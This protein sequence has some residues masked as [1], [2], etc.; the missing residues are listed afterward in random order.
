MANAT[1]ITKSIMRQKSRRKQE[2]VFLGIAAI[3]IIACVVAWL[4]LEGVATTGEAMCGYEEHTHS[5]GCYELV[6]ICGYEEGEALSAAPDYAAIEADIRAE[7][8]AEAEVLAEEQALAQQEAE[9]AAAAEAEAAGEDPEAARAAVAAAAEPLPT[10]DEVALREAV[11]AAYAAAEASVETHVH[12]ESCT[13]ERLVCD[14]EEHTHVPSCYSN[15]DIDEEAPE[16]WE[17]TFAHV[18]LT[19]EWPEDLLAI[20]ETQIGYCESEQN[21]QLGDDGER[22]G[23]TR[24]G[25]WYEN[26]Y[27]VWDG[28]FVLFCMEYAGI[29]TDYLPCE[30]GAYAWTAALQRASAYEPAHAYLPKPGDIV[31]FNDDY[32]ENDKADR[33]GIVAS[34]NDD[35][36]E[37]VVI[38]GDV[39][40][41]VAKTPY[42]LSS[43][44]IQGYCNVADRQALAEDPSNGVI[45]IDEYDADKNTPNDGDSAGEKD[46]KPDASDEDGNENGDKDANN[47]SNSE[48]DSL[49]QDKEPSTPS[50]DNKTEDEKRVPSEG[51]GD[52][53]VPTPS[54]ESDAV[55]ADPIYATFINEDGEMILFAEV[56]AQA[57]AE[58]E[59]ED[60]AAGDD[61]E[62]SQQGDGEQKGDKP[63]EDSDLRGIDDVNKNTEVE[64]IDFAENI[65]SS[66]VEYQL[67]G[68]EGWSVLPDDAVINGEDKVKFT[69]AYRLDANTLSERAN[70]IAFSATGVEELEAQ[71]G[72]VLDEIS[73]EE[74]GTYKIS[75]DG[76]ITI[77]FNKAAVEQNQEHAIDGSV[78]F[79]CRATSIAVDEENQATLQF[80]SS[81]PLMLTVVKNES[82]NDSEKPDNESKNEL[83]AAGTN[84]DKA[85]SDSNDAGD[86]ATFAFTKIDAETKEP[87]DGAEFELYEYLG[88]E[89]VDAGT[90]I[91]GKTDTPGLVEILV[92]FDTA[93]RLKETKAP[94]GYQLMDEV[95]FDV[96]SANKPDEF[97]EEDENNSSD[98]SDEQLSV[99]SVEGNYPDDYEFSSKFER[100]EDGTY[101]LANDPE[102]TSITVKKEW[103]DSD[104]HTDSIHVQLWRKVIPEGS[105]EVT[106]E[107]VP[108][109]EATL[110]KNGQE[111]WMTCFEDLPLV[112]QRKDIGAV[113]YEYYVVEDK[114][115]NLYT[116]VSITAEGVEGISSAQPL[117]AIEDGAVKLNE[118]G[119]AAS[120]TGITGGTLIITNKYNDTG[121]ELPATGGSGTLPFTIGGG[122]AVVGAVVFILARRRHAR[123]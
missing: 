79:E 67:A 40:N 90:I 77:A 94:A 73:H 82:E 17:A 4:E 3:M 64:P 42:P 91:S 63:Q 56:S 50:S 71:K 54:D 121:Y 5:V 116:L 1:D 24:Y 123:S 85:T 86:Y 99:T 51:S 69:L 102:R 111:A 95:Y 80:G 108:G 28:L 97:K 115:N 120:V 47:E 55:E 33:V 58:E 60:N 57:M 9:D 49:S 106:H 84:E 39:N 89:Y 113:A 2:L 70:I 68:G 14:L 118:D 109:A 52:N 101:I 32:E 16:D 104:K 65:I 107:E 13:E 76:V 6:N 36:D 10:V 66:S 74:L 75:K 119:S 15:N 7:F 46:D 31:F 43:E 21:F 72:D 29:D 45:P 8:E 105:D 112:G 30:S 27:G 38:E 61:E 88:D 23:Y 83:N 103:V 81:E 53:E 93:Y 41:T 100:Q 34:I 19:G 35:L 37:L 44:T 92:K 18:D 22:H 114:E 11:D 78:S 25:D 87:L 96:P 110:S 26:P 122:C 59:S 117:V 98:T 20:A 12:D 48:K 62:Q